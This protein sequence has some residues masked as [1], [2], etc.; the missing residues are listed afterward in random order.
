MH[1]KGDLEGLGADLLQ[2]KGKDIQ[3]S[4]WGAVKKQEKSVCF[5]DVRGD[6]EGGDLC[7]AALQC[8]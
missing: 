4:M 5:V 1:G 7:R 3:E 8:G 6:P 2:Q